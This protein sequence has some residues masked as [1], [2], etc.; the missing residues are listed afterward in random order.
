M[1][2]YG[3]GPGAVDVHGNTLVG[4]LTDKGS[5]SSQRNTN[6]EA[7]DGLNAMMTNIAGVLKDVV[8]ELKALKRPQPD[9]GNS[10]INSG[11]G[12]PYFSNRPD[13]DEHSQQH[14]RNYRIADQ[15]TCGA[16]R[17]AAHNIFNSNDGNY[18]GKRQYDNN[19]NFNSHDADAGYQRGSYQGARE[20]GRRM[21]P[22]DRRHYT[23]AKQH[24]SVK[25]PAFTGK[26]DWLVWSARF[27]AIATRYGWDDE[28][29]LDQLLP[30]IEAKPVS[31]TYRSY[32]RRSVQLPRYGC[33]AQQRYRVIHTARSYAA[34]FSKR[35]QKYGETAEY[36]AADLKMLYDK[37]HGYRDR[38][39]RN[40][41]LVRRFLDGLLDEEVR[42]EVEYHKEPETI[43]EAVFHVVNFIQ[44]RN[45]G[46]QKYNKRGTR[47]TLDDD[48]NNMG[49]GDDYE[50]SHARVY[51]M[52]DGGIEMRKRQDHTV[53]E[54][55]KSRHKG[56]PTQKASRR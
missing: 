32:H 33:R 55:S 43:D 3:D 35:S 24:H 30:R 2:N 52:P 4:D 7:T 17:T 18:A 53:W 21:E 28:D 37:G 9:I 50:D 48:I 22:H 8:S 1:K 19:V 40:E 39:S 6:D 54:A 38:I 14:G 41:D 15:S 36:F 31:L 45:C 11:S 23:A 51:R 5:F 12:R 29:K 20:R 46:D 47:R 13:A 26:E 44:T 56:R 25:I 42:F 16:A 49:E 27:E 10:H 34:K